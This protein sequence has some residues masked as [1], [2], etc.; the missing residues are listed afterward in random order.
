[1]VLG[2]GWYVTLVND[3]SKKLYK[4]KRADK[5]VRPYVLDG[6][7]GQRFTLDELEICDFTFL[8]LVGEFD[9]AITIATR[10]VKWLYNNSNR[11]LQ[12]VPEKDVRYIIY[13]MQQRINQLDQML[14]ESR[15]YADIEITELNKKLKDARSTNNNR[16]G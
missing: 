6:L 7:V 10:Q 3:P 4:I 9:K 16:N 15:E 2:K 14:R 12:V 11:Y 5:H 1:M 8:T 13:N